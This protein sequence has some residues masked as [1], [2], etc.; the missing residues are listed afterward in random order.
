MVE[1]TGLE[2][3]RAFIAHLGFKSLSLRHILEIGWR[4]RV[5]YRIGAVVQLVRIPACHA[6]GRGFESRPLRQHNE[7]S[8]EMLGLFCICRIW[9]WALTSLRLES[10]PCAPPAVPPIQ[11]SLSRNAG[12][13]CICRIGFGLSRAFG[14]SP[15]RAR[16][17]PLRQHN[18]ASLA[19]SRKERGAFLYLSNLGLDSHEPSA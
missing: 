10:R 8:A 15:G 17:R 5:S 9:V 6:G 19:H 12:A 18:E 2:N 11:R 14:L 3:R 4:H 16:P 1:S 13:F 7:A